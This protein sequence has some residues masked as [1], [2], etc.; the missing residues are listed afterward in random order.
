MIF[1][2]Q[3]VFESFFKI[4]CAIVVAFMIGYWFYKFVIVDSDIGVVDYAQLEDAEG[5]EFPALAVCLVNPF[6]DQTLMAIN[7]NITRGMYLQY[8]NGELYDEMLEQIDYA[9]VTIDLGQYFQLFFHRC[10]KV[11]K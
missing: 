5:I 1:C 9:N 4:T 7:S 2:S 6:Q 11:K 10:K 8:L 3:K